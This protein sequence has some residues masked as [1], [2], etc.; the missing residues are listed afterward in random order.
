MLLDDTSELLVGE[1][2]DDVPRAESNPIGKESAVESSEAFRGDQLA[3]AVERG[4]I[5][6]TSAV[7]IRWL[8]HHSGFHDIYNQ[9]KLIEAII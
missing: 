2:H 4:A 5:V 1:E 6:K 7:G 8:I 9:W 3:C